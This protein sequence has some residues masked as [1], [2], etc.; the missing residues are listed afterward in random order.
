MDG[1]QEV[2]IW[3]RKSK[4]KLIADKNELPIIGT[5]MQRSRQHYGFSLIHNLSQSIALAASVLT[6]GE[7]FDENFNLKQH[8]ETVVETISNNSSKLHTCLHKCSSL[9]SFYLFL[10]IINKREK[11][12][13]APQ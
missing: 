6:L 11:D 9:F 1:L 12:R 8:I 5:A 3:V 7:I 13:N 10:L 2:S 4:L